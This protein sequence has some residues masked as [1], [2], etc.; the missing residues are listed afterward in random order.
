MN[1]IKEQDIINKKIKRKKIVVIT[2]AI[3][4]VVVVLAGGL[5]LKNSIQ[6][7]KL[8]YCQE[9]VAGDQN[10]KGN[11]DTDRFTDI[12]KQFAIG[13]NAYGYAVFKNPDEAL[14]ELKK[15]F[16]SGIDLIQTEF[17]LKPLSQDNYDLYNTYGA[18]VTD[19]TNEAQA[20]AAFVS[21]FMDIYE[22]S[23][24]K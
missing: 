19:G 17:D 11:V 16:S 14:K 22:N 20:E 3:F 21:E 5:Y 15:D 13:A 9:Y 2:T 7:K 1:K 12:S 6:K 8:L 24:S 4:V 10:I 18:E 23:F